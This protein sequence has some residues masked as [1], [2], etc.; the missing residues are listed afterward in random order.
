MSGVKICSAFSTVNLTKRQALKQSFVPDI[1]NK[2]PQEKKIDI[3][4][5]AASL[6]S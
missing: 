3:Q 4:N 5:H 2:K 1:A 6:V